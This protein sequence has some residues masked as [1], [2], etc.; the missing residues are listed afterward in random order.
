WA[1][2][3]GTVL[4]SC[5][6]VSR[7]IVQQQIFLTMSKPIRWGQYLL[8]KWIGIMLVNALL[9]SVTGLGVYSMAQAL[10]WMRAVDARDRYVVE[11]EVLTAREIAGPEFP[12]P[13]GI[14]GE[15]HRR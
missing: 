4:F 3:I 15:V 6:S 11:S 7:D 8:G 13:G 14:E 2:A 10:R 5:F 1:L 9:I 12:A